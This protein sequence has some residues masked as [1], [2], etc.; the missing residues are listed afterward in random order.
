MARKLYRAEEIIG[1]LRT[2]EVDLGKGSAV[3]EAVGNSGSS[4]RPSSG[5]RRSRGATRGSGQT[6]EGTGARTCPAQATRGRSL[7]GP[8]HPQGGGNGKLLSPARRREAVRHAQTTLSGSERQACRVVGQCRAT[9][10]YV[11]PQTDDED[12]LRALVIALAHE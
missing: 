4:I 12:R 11:A 9:Q 3:P 10:Q 8:W 1:Q 2:V 7:V 5:R 6:A